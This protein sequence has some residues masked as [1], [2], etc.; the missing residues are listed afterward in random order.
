MRYTKL[1]PISYLIPSP[2]LSFVLPFVLA[3]AGLSFYVNFARY[4]HDEQES[5][6]TYQNDRFDFVGDLDSNAKNNLPS[7]C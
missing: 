6:Q 5:F 3:Y 7:P 4:H 2:F 1:G